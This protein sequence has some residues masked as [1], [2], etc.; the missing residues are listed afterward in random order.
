MNAVSRPADAASTMSNDCQHASRPAQQSWRVS[1]SMLTAIVDGETYES[2]ALKF[3]VSRTAVERRIK[4][5]AVKLSKSAQVEGLNA[6]GAAFVRRLR[7]HRDAILAALPTF[8]QA[9]RTHVRDNRI[10]S[11][12]EIMQAG[13]RIKARSARSAHDLAL[14][15]LLFATGARPLEIARLEVRDYLNSDGSVRRVSEIRDGVSIS[16]KRR[17]LYF[18]SARLNEAMDVYLQERLARGL[19]T[20]VP[21]QFRGLDAHS[22]L[23]LSGA[24]EG[25]R[26]TPY[27][28]QGQRRFL[29]RPILETFS[30]LFR[31]GGLQDVSALSARRALALRLIARG[32][33][34][35]QIGN[36]LGISDRTAVRELLGQRK[37][38]LAELMDEPL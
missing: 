8:E 32:A 36:L 12:E 5:V 16:G 26:V 3:G 19:G 22:R 29:C 15:Y 28:V 31:Y 27:G 13:R 7:L 14:F 24:G 33:D 21:A 25:F 17:D 34:E 30:K 35:G 2:V 10:P 6:E 23:F 18:T 37:P 38:E 4:D 20:G 11:L 9:A 1:V